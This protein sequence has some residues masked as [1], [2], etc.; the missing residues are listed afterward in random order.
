MLC[1]DNGLHLLVRPNN[2]EALGPVG[3]N[4]SFAQIHMCITN[5]K[6]EL[7]VTY[8]INVIRSILF[9]ARQKQIEFF[10]GL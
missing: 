8:N 5:Y 7:N 9:R 10:V 3:V 1:R 6:D 4:N 2:K